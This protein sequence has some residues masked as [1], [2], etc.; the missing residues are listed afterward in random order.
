[1]FAARA[2]ELLDIPGHLYREAVRICRAFKPT[3]DYVH[4]ALA[5]DHGGRPNI[6][7]AASF[8]PNDQTLRELIAQQ[9]GYKIFLNFAKLG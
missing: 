2:M 6:L 9:S 8:L 4:S 5:L 7:N 3:I 1:M